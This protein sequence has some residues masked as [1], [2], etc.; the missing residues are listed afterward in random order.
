MLPT[1]S[2]SHVDYSA[3]AGGAIA[4]VLIACALLAAWRYQTRRGPLENLV[5][6]AGAVIG[7]LG[8]CSVAVAAVLPAPT[9]HLRVT[10]GLIPPDLL[11]ASKEEGASRWVELEALYPQDPRPHGMAAAAW[12]RSGDER[13]A[14]SELQ[15]ALASPLLHAPEIDPRLEVNLRIML[16]GAQLSQ[17]EFSEA[18]RSA[19]PL[20]PGVA[21]LDPRVQD[22][23][24]QMKACDGS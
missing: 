8:V 15:R 12:H 7:F 5:A 19:E 23:M 10:A 22:A 3:H 24:K 13:L 2:A 16:I 6:S 11:P 21:T 4:G 17:K 9:L 1:S 14:E 20:C 18:R